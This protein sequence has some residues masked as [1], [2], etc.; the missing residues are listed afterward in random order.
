VADVAALLTAMAGNDPADVATNAA[1]RHKRDYLAALAGASLNGK[2]LGVLQFATGALPAVDG[3]FAQ[4]VA[5]LKARGAVIVVLK[6]YKP[7]AAL[8]DAELLVLLT[9]LK[10]DLNAYLATTPRAVR[11]RT[12]ASVIAFNRAD[13]RELGL[14]NQ[15]LFERAQATKGLSDP[16]YVKARKT[17][18]RAA[19]ADGIDRLIAEHSLDA[20]IAPSDGPASRVDVLTGDHITGMA[21]SLPAIAGYPHL[22]V[23]MGAVDG[24]PVGISFIGQAWT[25][26]RL[27]ALGAAYERAAHR[28]RAPT[29]PA[30]VEATS[31]ITKLLAPQAPFAKKPH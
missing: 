9:E 17:T 14:F 30:S 23:P 5:L 15:D 8:G 12:L 22:T 31:D 28:R 1:D 6:D 20:L 16:R 24:M 4:A 21:S 25:E 27:L 29:Y 10:V 3:L 13:P 19:G 18:N 2:R 26:D 11:T 7:P